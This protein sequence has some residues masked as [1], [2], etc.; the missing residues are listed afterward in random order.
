MKSVLGILA[1][2]SLA[3]CA[4]KVK[5]DDMTF[6]PI[7][8]SVEKRIAYHGFAEIDSNQPVC[9]GSNIVKAGYFVEL[10]PPRKGETESEYQVYERAESI[11]AGLC[12]DAA[13]WCSTQLDILCSPDDDDCLKEK[14]MGKINTCRVKVVDPIN[15][16]HL[17]PIIDMD[18]WIPCGSGRDYYTSA[19]AIAGTTSGAWIKDLER[20]QQYCLKNRSP[21][22]C[23]AIVKDAETKSYLIRPDA[24]RWAVQ[25]PSKSS[26]RIEKV[27]NRIFSTAEVDISP[28][29]QFL[30]KRH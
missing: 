30:E 20:W 9:G 21:D 11:R 22:E 18:G 8:G 19:V 23:D 24:S 27:G 1:V 4:S 14:P 5:Y 6:S 16:P 29:C 7:T 12:A 17:H 28:S 2:V 15:K 25:I 26:P 10:R 3:G 13:L